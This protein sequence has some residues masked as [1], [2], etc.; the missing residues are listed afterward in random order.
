MS[1]QQKEETPGVA[2]L[3]GLACVSKAGSHEGGEVFVAMDGGTREMGGS[4]EEEKQS[5]REAQTGGGKDAGELTDRGGKGVEMKEVEDRN[6]E[7]M[8]EKEG[9]GE[10]KGTEQERGK[11][12]RQSGV[13]AVRDKSS[14]KTR[15]ME[16]TGKT[17]KEGE[18]KD[19]PKGM[20]EEKQSKP[21][22]K[23]GQNPKPTPLGLSRP[24]SSTRSVRGTAKRDIIAKFQQNCLE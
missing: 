14:K 4:Q 12:D 13:E 16:G 24:R 22:K 11:I 8:G 19:K 18:L 20:E 17:N 10:T 5:E 3:V 23:V 6:K 21:Q 1:S 15:V 7:G 9:E 2:E